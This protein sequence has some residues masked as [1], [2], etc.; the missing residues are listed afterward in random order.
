MTAI[1]IVPVIS[2][3][4]PKLSGENGLDNGRQVVP[5]KNLKILTSGRKKNPMA[6]VNNERII[7][8]VTSI[9]K[10]PQKKRI[11]AISFSLNLDREVL[12]YRLTA[13]LGFLLITFVID[14]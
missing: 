6:S 14:C 12:P 7:P 10:I 2:G 3:R 9:E 8:M 5:V 4:T 1:N 11:S 13:L